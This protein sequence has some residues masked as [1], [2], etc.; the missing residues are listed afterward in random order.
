LTGILPSSTKWKPIRHLVIDH[1]ELKRELEALRSQTEERF[2]GVFTVLD[3]LVSDDT[4]LNKKIGFI[5][6]ATRNIEKQ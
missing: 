4:A 5:D 1:A 3:N 6:I 2:Q